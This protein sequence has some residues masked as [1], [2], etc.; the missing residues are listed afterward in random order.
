MKKQKHIYSVG[1]SV[2]IWYFRVFYESKIT[3][4]EKQR[5]YKIPFAGVFELSDFFC[6]N[7]PM[8]ICRILSN[9]LNSV[10][11]IAC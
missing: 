7:H 1:D 6:Y 2:I 11:N 4:K 9:V 5:K 10:F 8:D 3:K